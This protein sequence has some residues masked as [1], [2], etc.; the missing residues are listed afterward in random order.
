MKDYLA[1]LERAS[2][3]TWSAYVPDLPG[4]TTFGYT[5]EEAAANVREAIDGHIRALR[6]KGQPIPEPTSLPEVVHVA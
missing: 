3:G 5:R 4:C 1:I 6:G 2:D